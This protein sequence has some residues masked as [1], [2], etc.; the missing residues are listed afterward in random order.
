MFTS[1]SKGFTLTEILIVLSI[2]ILIVSLSLNLYPKY[3]EKMELT[4]F[5]QQ[6]EEDLYYTQ[7][8]AISHELPMYVYLNDHH[9]N[10]SSSVGGILLQR[11][12]PKDITFFKG[13]LGFKIIFN[14]EGSPV[15]SGV[16]Y[17]QGKQEK[18]KITIYL[19]KGR[20]KIE[21]V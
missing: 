9:Y 8:Y 3:I 6:F 1:N 18:F 14:D 11:A 7:Q 15:T 10:I 19:G 12:N 20:M 21:K 17:I 2:F 4:R 5:V 13:T 16:V